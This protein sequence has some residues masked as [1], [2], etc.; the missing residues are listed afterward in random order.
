MNGKKSLFLIS[1]MLNYTIKSMELE[2]KPFLNNSDVNQNF[3]Q[4]NSLNE[5]KN[6]ESKWVHIQGKPL[7]RSIRDIFAGGDIDLILN[8]QF[9][10]QVKAKPIFLCCFLIGVSYTY[11]T[12]QS[13][14]K[15]NKPLVDSLKNF[16]ENQKD[17]EKR[18]AKPN[19]FEDPLHLNGAFFLLKTQE[20]AKQLQSFFKDFSCIVTEDQVRSTQDA[21]NPLAI[22]NIINNVDKR[23]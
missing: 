8:N 20:N 13:S 3:K 11:K 18:I 22:C 4:I 16:Y 12:D 6:N 14:L 1:F 21:P 10:N 5:T 2:K 23:E 9:V 7:A 15:K 19:K 17:D